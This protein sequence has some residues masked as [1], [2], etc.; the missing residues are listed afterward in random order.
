MRDL[1]DGPL[2]QIQELENNR[3]IIIKRSSGLLRLL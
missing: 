3:L 1:F 2:A